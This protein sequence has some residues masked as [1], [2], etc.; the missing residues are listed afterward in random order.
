MLYCMEA[1]YVKILSQV[2]QK[3]NLLTQMSE[4]GFKLKFQS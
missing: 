2:L 3:F 1:C 4:K